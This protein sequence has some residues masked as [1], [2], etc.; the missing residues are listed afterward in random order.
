MEK[1]FFPRDFHGV[2]VHFVGIKGTGM[3]ALVELLF[4]RGAVITGSDVTERFY[5]DEILERLGIEPLPFGK[6]NITEKIQLV[7]YSSAYSPEKNPDLAE[8]RLL[9]IPMMLYSEALGALSRNSYSCGICGVH[10]KT[11]TTGLVGTIMKNLDLPSQVLA[12]SIIASFGNSCTM[13]TCSFSASEGQKYFIAET[14]E[15][16]RHFMS[17]SPRKIIL[18]SVESD[19]QDFYP[20]FSDIQNAFVDYICLLPQNGDLIFCA[21]DKGAFETALIASKRRSDI[22][23]IPYGENAQG[24]FGVSFGSVSGGKQHFIIG[25]TECVLH[26]PGRH[27]VLNAAAAFALAYRLLNEAGKNPRDFRE[28]IKKG[29]EEFSGGK[30]RSEVTGRAK[31]KFGQDIIFIDDYGHHPTAIK[32][33]L[34][35]F[36]QFY[37]NHKIIV[38]FMSHTYTRT[39]ALLDE[40]ADSFGS[41]DFVIINKIYGSAREQPGTLSVTG[42]ILAERTAEY[43]PHVVYAAEF[44]EACEIAAEELNKKTEFPDGYVFVTM[45]A[46]DNFK[47]GQMVLEKFKQQDKL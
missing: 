40:F 34:D 8:A 42:K 2:H 43:H 25:D 7:I 5:T 45:G 44:Q 13:T 21:D 33:T 18:T 14:C 28:Q 20:T 24:N 19:H 10:G 47:V 17:F 12:G 37:K 41:A 16:Q 26:V 3:A 22:N 4:A 46:G 6:Q 15:Y 9:G 31:N 11:T 27:N 39:A 29:I 36:R 35:G 1:T 38:D 23:L 30:R 32:T